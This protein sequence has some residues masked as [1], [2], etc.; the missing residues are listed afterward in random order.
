MKESVFDYVNIIYNKDSDTV[1]YL[2]HTEY[3]YYSK[4][5]K[6]WVV[7]HVDFPS[8]GATG[9]LDINSF[10]W[11]L[12]DKLCVTGVF[13]GGTVCNNWQAS[14]VCSDILKRDGFWFR[15][16]TWKYMTWSFGGGEARKNGMF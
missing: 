6:K 12:H 1:G 4:R 7:A 3:K 16:R 15:A 2:V 14:M 9:A 10:A 8:D 5:Y 11:L 13:E